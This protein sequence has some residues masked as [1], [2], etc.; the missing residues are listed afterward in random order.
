MSTEDPVIACV[1]DSALWCTGTRYQDKT[2]NLVHK[3]LTGSD[4]DTPDGDPIPPAHFRARG[5][6]TIGY[7]TPYRL[8]QLDN[9]QE[10]LAAAANDCKSHIEDHGFHADECKRP[11]GPGLVEGVRLQV[12]L[13][14]NGRYLDPDGDY[15]GF[16]KD[17]AGPWYSYYQRSDAQ[18]IN[19]LKWTIARDI[20]WHWPHIFDQIE[21]F[22]RRGT[23]KPDLDV[24]R[25]GKRRVG[26]FDGPVDSEPPYAEEVDVLLINGGTN[27]I[28]LS[29]LN[30]PVKADRA[31]IR[32]AVR[33]HCYLDQKE[34]LA[35]A[36]K[37]FPN[38]IIY[39]VGYYP[40]ASEWTSRKKAKDFLSAQA[41]IIG[42]IGTVV[43]GA[44]TNALNFARAQSYWMRRAVSEMAREDDGPGMVF[45]HRG[46]G[47]V[48]AFDAPEAWSWGV[49][50]DQ[51]DDTGDLR[52]QA[53]DI[54][55]DD[56]TVGC[57]QAS[58]GH[59]NTAGCEQTADAIVE[60]HN[61]YTHLGLATPTAEQTDGQPSS[62]REACENYKLDP[63]GDGVRYCM[64][65]RVVD[66][67]HVDIYTGDSLPGAKSAGGGGA[68]RLDPWNDV[69]L[70]LEP[71]RAGGAER[72]RLESEFD[73]FQ[74]GAT[75][76]FF[77]DPMMGRQISADVGPIPETNQW[78]DDGTWEYQE[79]LE[80]D[81]HDPE[82]LVEADHDWLPYH[83]DPR[84]DSQPLRLGMIEAIKLDVV[85]TNPW[86]LERIEV[87]LNGIMEFDTD[88]N[89]G[90]DGLSG[91]H[92]IV[93]WER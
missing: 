66:S 79:H 54:K 92:Q 70:R 57:T 61:E 89:H 80:N 58:I 75:D 77:I 29:W 19:Q 93:V 67:I 30:N 78:M 63:E 38:A 4:T 48:N 64:S 37:R 2:P 20:G 56:S 72:F 1:G 59:P 50:A 3:R 43:T 60:S 88:V 46:F 34:L 71:G 44:V 74:A 55:H 68:G 42:Q 73:D 41:G 49:P 8:N 10:E 16:V 84:W 15:Y 47:V 91:D 21:Q 28:E 17:S 85:D 25:D 9:T 45:V 51:T 52:R 83:R 82:H 24:P 40:Y 27:D 86:A 18:D 26:L 32:E 62:L 87:E 31:A 35:K 11:V 76:H 33:T 22:P 90:G 6:A 13:N 39:L 81:G 23:A 5:G 14:R 36:R 12:Q 65:H 53:C 7:R 69:Y